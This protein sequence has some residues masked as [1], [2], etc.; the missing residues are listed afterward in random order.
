MLHNSSQK[1]MTTTSILF[2]ATDFMLLGL[3]VPS[4]TMQLEKPR[5]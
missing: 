4:A 1:F 3:D 2:L 5:S